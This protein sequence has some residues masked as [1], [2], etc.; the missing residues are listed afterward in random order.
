MTPA[1]AI[2]RFAGEYSFLSN[3]HPS[4]VEWMGF[5]V[6]TVEHAFQLAKT[7]DREARRAIAQASTPA[8]AKRL[9]RD[10][11]LRPGW[12]ES[13]SA[14]MGALLVQKFTRHLDL[15]QALLSTGQ[16]ELVEGNDWGDTFWGVCGGRGRNQLG[17]QLMEVRTL[18]RSLAGS[19]H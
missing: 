4:P 18:L 9:G 6:E 2:T 16:V 10:V 11:Q 8:K 3:F 13:K 1:N 15:A 19:D 14:L 7:L 5:K 17:H 12:E